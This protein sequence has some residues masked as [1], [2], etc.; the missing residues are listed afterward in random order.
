MLHYFFTVGNDLAI[1]LT[2]EIPAI[3]KDRKKLDFFIKNSLIIKK[4]II[5]IDEFDQSI[6]HIFNYGHT[7]G[8]ALEALTNYAIPHGQAIT[9]GMDLA[10]YISFQKKFIDEM[11]FDALHEILIKNIPKFKFDNFSIDNYL[12][13]LSKDKKNKDNKIGCILYRSIGKVEKVFV[14]NDIWFRNT[15]I[16]YFKKYN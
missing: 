4:N 6:R 2:D 5:E 15:L 14:E 16:N 3:L 8:H 10:N 12:N 9:I 13:A 11:Q 7:F 1:K